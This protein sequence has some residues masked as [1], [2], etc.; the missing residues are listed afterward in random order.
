ME[1]SRP[2]GEGPEAWVPTGA[3]RSRGPRIEGIKTRA[4]D[5]KRPFWLPVPGGL[6]SPLTL[7]VCGG[8]PFSKPPLVFSQ[9]PHPLCGN[10]HLSPH[11]LALPC[12]QPDICMETSSSWGLGEAG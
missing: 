11:W 2:P 12:G 10:L 7:G 5:S 3:G 1:L 8:G 6:G 4:A 9:L